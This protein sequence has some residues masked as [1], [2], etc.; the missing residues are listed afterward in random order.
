MTLETPQNVDPSPTP[1]PDPNPN[2][3]PTPQA[4][5]RDGLP[6]DIKADAT[7][8]RYA[9]VE[10]L[11][12]GHLETKKLVGSKLSLPAADAAPEAWGE[13][14]NAIGRPAEAADYDIKTVEL[15]VDASADDRAALVEA[16]KPFKELAHK[17]GLTAS[18]ATALSEFDLARN[19]DF[20]AKGQ[21]EVDALQA[22]LGNDYAPKLAAAQAA[23]KQ[24][25]PGEVG[26]KLSIE[27]DRK[28]GSG[29]LLKGFMRLAEI[30]G[31]HDLIETN[32]VEGFGAVADAQA[33]ITELQGDATWR[34]KLNS[35]DAATKAQYDR[36]L[37]LAARQ[38][39]QRGG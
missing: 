8:S 4:T 36:L 29:E 26:E 27:L 10:A 19:A 5:W 34:A 20:F 7:L 22:E 37:R 13:F 16:T 2:P 11:A 39:Q 32:N 33:K 14:W 23:A 25:F 15:P 28:V 9:D 38:A 30:M 35:G 17:L 21:A 31:E 12:R 24:I 18:Q 6:D 3:D 1:N